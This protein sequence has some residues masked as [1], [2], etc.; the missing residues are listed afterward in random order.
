MNAKLGIAVLAAALTAT[1][2]NQGDKERAQQRTDEAGRK[3]Q[4]ELQQLGTE[5][6]RDAQKV[7]SELDKGMNGN[8]NPSMAG[9]QEKLQ[10]AERVAHSESEKAGKVLDRA[11][12]IARVKAKLASDVGL[13]SVGQVRVEYSGGIVTLR[14]SVVSADQRRLA[15]QA[16]S[17]TDGVQQVRNELIVQP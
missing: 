1:S 9:A 14:G 16:A 5:A 12:V 10:R 15:E 3:A 17:Q 6:K 8:V 4:H 11:T 13:S 7:R 2:C